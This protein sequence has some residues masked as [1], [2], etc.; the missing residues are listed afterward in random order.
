MPPQAGL[1]PNPSLSCYSTTCLAR[2]VEVGSLSAISTRNR[3]SAHMF[4]R[5][6]T[7]VFCFGRSLFSMSST[8][9]PSHSL[10]HRL[11]FQDFT[12]QTRD[13]LAQA[14]TSTLHA[15]V[16]LPL[17]SELLTTLLSFPGTLPF[18]TPAAT[19]IIPAAKITTEPVTS[20]ATRGRVHGSL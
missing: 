6:F 9:S 1:L 16:S 11:H 18:L 10:L 7:G 14:D 13:T 19:S 17:L 12:L 8:M 3:Q 15:R 4:S 2:T 5:P 20:A